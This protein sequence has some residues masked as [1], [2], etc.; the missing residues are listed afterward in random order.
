MRIVVVPVGP[1]AEDS[2]RVLEPRAMVRS[3]DAFLKES[4]DCWPW[5]VLEASDAGQAA[6]AARVARC[7]KIVGT[8]LLGA[9]PTGR[10]FAGFARELARPVLCARGPDVDPVEALDRCWF[11]PL[12]EVGLMG[13]NFE[14]V[15]AILSESDYGLL[16]L[17]PLECGP[18]GD[19]L[20]PPRVA[21][22]LPGAA[23]VL[24]VVHGGPDLTLHGINALL[25]AIQAMVPEDANVLAQALCD[26]R[27]APLRL[28]VCVLYACEGATAPSKS[29]TAEVR[30]GS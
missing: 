3:V 9:H 1:L 23:S 17:V 5:L 20:L 13:F 7:G 18:G 27:G 8:L 12:L 29:G 25:G 26:E 4:G 6:E 19:Y 24:A 16:D 14:D 15:Q 30:A 22:S 28:A 2:V 10:T 21:E 11:A